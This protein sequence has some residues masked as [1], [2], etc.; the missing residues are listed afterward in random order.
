MNKLLILLLVGFFSMASF[1]SR[2]SGMCA[3]LDLQ[4]MQEIEEIVDAN[5]AL[6]FAA[7]ISQTRL[8]TELPSL[9]PGL[10]WRLRESSWHP[11]LIA[12]TSSSASVRVHGK[13]AE[14]VVEFSFPNE[15]PRQNRIDFVERF[16]RAVESS[17]QAKQL[18][19]IGG[20]S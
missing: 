18:K 10:N 6:G 2:S 9:L 7:E 5:W 15:A 16:W 14:F 1:Q 3:Q 13:K 12:G 8:L 17:L 19:R 20:V 11:D 4:I